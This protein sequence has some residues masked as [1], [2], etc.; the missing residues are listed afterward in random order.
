[1]KIENQERHEPSQVKIY[2]S[3]VHRARKPQ[4][5]SPLRGLGVGASEQAQCTRSKKFR[6][7][8]W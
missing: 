3:V 2:C 7:D 1:M 4:S 8:E 6:V 5:V